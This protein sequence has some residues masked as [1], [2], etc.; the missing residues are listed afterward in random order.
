MNSLF[1]NFEYTYNLIFQIAFHNLYVS[2]QQDGTHINYLKSFET[3]YKTI[4]V[5]TDNR[6]TIIDNSLGV[7]RIFFEMYFTKELSLKNILVDILKLNSVSEYEWKHADYYFKTLTDHPQDYYNFDD[8][9]SEQKNAENNETHTFDDCEISGNIQMKISTHGRPENLEER[10]L[11]GELMVVASLLDS[12]ANLGGL[13]R[14]C[15]IFGVKQLVVSNNKVVNDKSFKSLSMSSEAWLDIS[16]VTENQLLNFLNDMKAKNYALIGVEQTVSSKKLD[17]FTF[18]EK[19][20]VLL[21]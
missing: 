1:L 20:L 19:A 5:I 11:V 21:G 12:P 8:F 17:K 16:E 3:I 10:K 18:P 4:S 2:A 9:T 15:E 14:T 13:A 6:K 7:D